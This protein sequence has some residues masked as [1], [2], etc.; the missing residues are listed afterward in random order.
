MRKGDSQVIFACHTEQESLE[1]SPE[2]IYLICLVSSPLLAFTHLHSANLFPPFSSYILHPI[3]CLIL[4]QTPRMR[5]KVTV[6]SWACLAWKCQKRVFQ[7]WT[8]LHHMK[9]L[10]HP[11]LLNTCTHKLYIKLSAY[12]L[13]LLLVFFFCFFCSITDVPIPSP[14]TSPTSTRSLL[15]ASLWYTGILLD[16]ITFHLKR[17]WLSWPTKLLSWPDHSLQ[18]KNMVPQT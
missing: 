9:C 11:E 17:N 14:F 15:P 12:F 8:T 6:H 18:F 7:A 1:K 2:L 16:S 10:L 5:R 3:L 4:A 13:T